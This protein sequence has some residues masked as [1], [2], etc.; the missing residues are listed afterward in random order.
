MRNGVSDKHRL[1]SEAKS[2]GKHVREPR[3]DAAYFDALYAQNEDPW[4]LRTRW[5]ERRKRAIALS[6]LPRERYEHAFEP[7]CGIGELTAMLGTRCASVTAWDISTRALAIA[8]E[9]VDAAH[10]QFERNTVPAHWPQGQFDLIVI[11]ELAY[12]LSGTQQRTLA[13][14]IARGLAPQGTLLACHWRHPIDDAKTSAL[15]AHRTLSDVS[16]LISVARYD[17]D[18]MV[19]DVWS[20]DGRSVATMA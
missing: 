3:D 2:Q 16:G 17:D 5:Y 14:L 9:R 4:N 15:E 13:Q 20:N 10:V 18:D 1:M 19:I 11:S 8:R 6:M 12:Y 7:G